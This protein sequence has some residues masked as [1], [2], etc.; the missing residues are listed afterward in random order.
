M[1][2]NARGLKLIKHFEGL[3]LVAYRDPVGIWTIGHGHTGADVTPGRRITAAEAEALLRRDLADA[4]G[5]VR[6]LVTTPL[7]ADQAAALISFAFNVGRGNLAAS[8]LLRKLNGGDVS[9]AAN[10]FG[11]WIHGTIRGK[12]TPLPGLVRRRGQ[13]RALFLG[14]PLDLSGRT[15]RAA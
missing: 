1:A 5:A 11:R 10:E 7:T 14:Q 3:R 4:D 6:D 8:T 12:K 9:G 15:S 2:I 13:E